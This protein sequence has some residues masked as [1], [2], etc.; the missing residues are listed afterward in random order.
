MVR[1]RWK[2]SGQTLFMLLIGL[3]IAQLTPRMMSDYRFFVQYYPIYR[4]AFMDR[5]T[6]PEFCADPKIAAFSHNP[7]QYTDAQRLLVGSLLT[8]HHCIDSAARILPDISSS[9]TTSELLAYQWGYVAWMQ[10]DTLTAVTLWRQ[11][12]DIDRGLLFQARQIQVADPEQAQKWYEAA[13]MTAASPQRQAETLTAYTEEMR[14]KMVRED[15]RGRLVYLEAYFGPDTAFGHR[16]GG[17]DDL[18]A[19]NYQS[20]FKQISQAIT[21]GVVDAE[22]WY[23]LGDAAWQ[24]DD[25]PTAERA[26]RAALNAPTQISWRRPW[27]LDRLATLLRQ[28]G[29]Q[30]EA[31]PF[32]EE[33]VRLNDYYLYANNL[34]MLYS[35]LGRTAEAQALCVRARNLAD[36]ATSEALPCEQ[37]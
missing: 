24:L 27:H 7:G 14:G 20:A 12:Q 15:F 8:S 10:G 31:L 11:I 37:P 25:L 28:S 33:A 5:S 6:A 16:L 35:D 30:A 29:R 1:T 26:F 17:Q 23:L 36:S 13:I 9:R 18:W 2:L 34:S 3:A 21:L 19:G 32:Q 4:Q 22:T